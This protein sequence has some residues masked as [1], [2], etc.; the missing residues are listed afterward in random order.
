MFRLPKIL[1]LLTRLGL[2][3]QRCSLVI[4]FDL[5]YT[6]IEYIQ[7]RGRARRPDSS[8]VL[9]V[10]KGNI[11]EERIIHRIQ[12][13]VSQMDAWK[14][15]LCDRIAD[16]DAAASQE[17]PEI[18]ID[19]SELQL[20]PEA[21]ED[22]ATSNEPCNETIDEPMTGTDTDCLVTKY[23]RVSY[24]SS[25]RLIYYYCSLLPIGCGELPCL[26]NFE[27]DQLGAGH[28]RVRLFLPTICPVRLVEGEVQSSIALAKRDAALKGCKA[29]YQA[30]E[31]DDHL[32]PIRRNVGCD[33]EGAEANNHLE[34]LL[35]G[36]MMGDGDLPLPTKKGRMRSIFLLSFNS[37]C[38]LIYSMRW[39]IFV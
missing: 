26:P 39:L 23:A 9:M 35:E 31:L 18:A 29:L 15:S 25:V 14:K 1:I 38:E 17:S 34:R 33:D 19:L 4:R 28:Y 3:I 13:S 12:V 24:I 37:L 30:G 36:M 7:S 21:Y 10:E 22:N 32:L 5:C 11:D 16:N 27:L 20:Q 6:M 8:F 2:D